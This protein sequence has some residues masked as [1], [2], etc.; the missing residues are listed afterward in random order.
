MENR[1]KIKL[2]TFWKNFCPYCKSGTICKFHSILDEY[3][4]NPSKPSLMNVKKMGKKY[5]LRIIYN[6]KEDKEIELSF[7]IPN[8][9]VTVIAG[10]GRNRKSILTLIFTENIFHEFFLIFN[11]EDIKK[12]KLINFEKLQRIYKNSVGE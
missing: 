3:G 9:Q 8:Q 6:G 4:I 2:V 10:R 1:Q 12:L 11:E 5:S 7:S